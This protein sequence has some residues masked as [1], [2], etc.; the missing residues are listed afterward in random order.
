MKN[1]HGT[2]NGLE[3]RLTGFEGKGVIKEIIS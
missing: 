1:S 3:Q 2:T